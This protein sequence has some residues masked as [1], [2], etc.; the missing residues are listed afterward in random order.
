MHWR[1]MPPPPTQMRLINPYGRSGDGPVRWK[2]LM[3]QET[4]SK[5]TLGGWWSGGG[6]H[7]GPH[8]AVPVSYNTTPPLNKPLLWCSGWNLPGQNMWNGRDGAEHGAKHGGDGTSETDEN[9]GSD[10]KYYF[11]P[12]KAH[13]SL[14]LEHSV[15]KKVTW[16]HGGLLPS[17]YEAGGLLAT[18]LVAPC[19]GRKVVL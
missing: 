17:A 18:H 5:A 6:F 7:A 13:A 1:E 3:D 9:T 16:G 8:L 4:L 11:E 2:W 15:G 12:R 10:A 19:S 14:P